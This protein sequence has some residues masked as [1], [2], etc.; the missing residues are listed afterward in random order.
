MKYFHLVWSALT[1]RKAR[2]I[3]TIVSIVAAFL[4]FGMLDSVR[5]VFVD[6]GH[7]VNGASQ[8]IT[9][10]KLGLGSQ[11]PLSLEA[12]IAAV[13]GVKGVTR[14]DWFGGIYQDPKNFFPSE[15]VG[16]NYFAVQRDLV[17]PPAQLKVFETTQ[18]GA[19]VGA[20]LA[21]RFG[22]KIG[23]QIPLEATIWPKKDGSNT[24]TFKLV[25]IYHA[26]DKRTK[27]AENSMLFRWKYFDEARAFGNGSVGWY[28]A[29]IASPD[30]ADRVAAAIDALSANSDHETKTQTANA[31]GTSMVSQFANIGLIVSG[32]MAAVFFTLILLTGNTMAQA[33]RERV[34]E[35][36]VLKTIGF[37]NRSVLGMVLA[38]AMLLVGIGGVIGMALAMAGVGG[39]KA[40][41]GASM[42]MANIGGAIWGTAIVLMLA[43]GVI[44]GV[45]P[46]LRG[47]RLKIV[48]ALAGR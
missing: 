4:L 36:A 37:S 29:Q 45:L 34:P 7:S 32:I 15:A 6:A 48:D 44:V 39:L 40:S 10:S 2:T 30:Q 12:Q 43:L 28:Q 31:F 8:L 47:M 27:P 18:D 19:V 20:S 1:R 41:L 5:T 21:K 13:P 38:E 14:L 46:A 9:M 17:L 24:W 25:G 42:P 16:A 23:D 3:F 33:V 35:L 26:A 11:I 22:W